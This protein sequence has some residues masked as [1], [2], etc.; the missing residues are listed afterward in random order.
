MRDI[1][2]Y[3][4]KKPDP[5]EPE[6]CRRAYITQYDKEF[7]QRTDAFITQ[8]HVWCVWMESKIINSLRYE[9]AEIYSTLQRRME[10]MI[11]GE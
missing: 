10:I 8:M 9:E 1:V 2:P 3:E 6:V 11:R 7:G 4:I 5:V